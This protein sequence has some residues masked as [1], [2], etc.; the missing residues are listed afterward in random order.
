VNAERMVVKGGT[1]TKKN[2]EI[3]ASQGNQYLGSTDHHRS[4][5]E[6]LANRKIHA[7]EIG[8]EI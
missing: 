1:N 2:A 5:D 8:E 3:E 6:R 7:K 4:Y